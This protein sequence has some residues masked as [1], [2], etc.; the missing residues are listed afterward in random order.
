MSNGLALIIGKGPHTYLYDADSLY[1]FN[2]REYGQSATG[3]WNEEGS[4]LR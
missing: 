2:R 4:Y 1:V 3:R